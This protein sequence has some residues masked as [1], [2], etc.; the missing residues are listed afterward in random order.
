MGK[1]HLIKDGA[2]RNKQIPKNLHGLKKV[3]DFLKFLL[4]VIMDLNKSLIQDLASQG[5]K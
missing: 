2:P 4:G 1:H 5:T 3:W